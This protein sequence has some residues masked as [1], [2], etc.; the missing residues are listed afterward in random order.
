MCWGEAGGWGVGVHVRA[1]ARMHTHTRTHTHRHTQAP[2]DAHTGV[3]G[4]Q[5]RPVSLP[6]SS[7]GLTPLPLPFRAVSYSDCS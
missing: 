3:G 4:A 2:R 1:R 7:R 6:V 5:S